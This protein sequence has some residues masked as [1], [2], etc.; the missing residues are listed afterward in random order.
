MQGREHAENTARNL[1]Q[2]FAYLYWKNSIRT[3]WNMP[4]L[5]GNYWEQLSQIEI[6][7][8]YASQV[9]QKFLGFTPFVSL[10][11]VSTCN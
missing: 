7:K 11:L 5:K 1:L 10:F 2:F 3:Y 8:V 9:N 4:L 6:L